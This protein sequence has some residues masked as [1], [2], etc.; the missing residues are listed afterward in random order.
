MRG[1]P[2][3]APGGGDR[4]RELDDPSVFVGALALAGDHTTAGLKLLFFSEEAQRDGAR[5]KAKQTPEPVHPFGLGRRLPKPPVTA[6]QGITFTI[7]IE[8]ALAGD[9]V[10]AASDTRF[11]QLEPKRGLAPLGG[12]RCATCSPP[13]GSHSAVICSSPS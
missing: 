7:G 8:I 13:P 5:L 4:H 12:A 6:L 2:C 3:F 11:C 1:G 9:I 10:V